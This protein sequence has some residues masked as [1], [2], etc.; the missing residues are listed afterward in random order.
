[1]MKKSL[2]HAYGMCHPRCV[3][4]IEHSAQSWNKVATTQRSTR[5]ES[6]TYRRK[7]PAKAVMQAQIARHNVIFFIYHPVL[8]K[9]Y[10][11]DSKGVI[12]RTSFSSLRSIPI[13]PTSVHNH[14]YPPFSTSQSPF[15]VH[16]ASDENNCRYN[17][18]AK[19]AGHRCLLS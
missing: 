4:R 12:A 7:E 6:S 10:T 8:K 3:H 1:M 9:S 17:Q 15:S 2:H 11:I 13:F 14:E 19:F 18:P 5:H 16:R